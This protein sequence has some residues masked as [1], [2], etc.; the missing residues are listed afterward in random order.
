MIVAPAVGEPA[1]QLPQLGPQQRIESDRRLVEHEQL[2][3]SEHRDG[4]RDAA[5]L[6]A[7]ERVDGL[8]RLVAEA[9][10]SMTRSTS[11]RGAP[12]MRAK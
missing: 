3:A 4:E 10:L 2:G 7:A 12:M 6:S 11:E 5:L 1:E 9:H 8:P